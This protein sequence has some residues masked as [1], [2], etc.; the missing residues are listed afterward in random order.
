MSLTDLIGWARREEVNVGKS[1]EKKGKNLFILFGPF[2][3]A[4]LQII[5]KREL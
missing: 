4:S 1:L 3:F 2:F 5:P